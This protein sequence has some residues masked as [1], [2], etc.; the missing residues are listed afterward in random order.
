MKNKNFAVA[1]I[2]MKQV[3]NSQLLTVTCSAT[4]AFVLASSAEEAEGRGIKLA[5]DQFPESEGYMNHSVTAT[6][7]PRGYNVVQ[8]QAQVGA[9]RL[10]LVKQFNRNSEQ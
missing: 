8:Q 4:I 5:K 7:V 3:L 10:Q 6:Q 9:L 1:L 2:A